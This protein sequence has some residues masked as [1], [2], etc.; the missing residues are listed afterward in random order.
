MRPIRVTAVRYFN[1]L[2]L[3]EGLDRLEDLELSTAAPSHIAGMLASGDAD[4]G[5]VSLVD[6]VRSATPFTVLPVGMIG[7]EGPTLTVRIYSAVEPERI[8][9][10]HA[11]T[12]SHTSVL[13]ARLLL[14]HRYGVRPRIVDFDARE[15]V[16]RTHGETDQSEWPE[17]LLMIGNKVVTDSPPAVRYPHQLDLG[18]QWHTWTSRPF[19][20]AAWMCRSEDL[21]DESADRSAAIRMAA[22][23]LDR[24]R[25]HNETRLDWIVTERAAEHRWP[26]DLARTYLGDLL[27]FDMGE[28]ERE[29][30]AHFLSLCAQSGYLP[31]ATLRFGS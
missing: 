12:D 23:L 19:V 1:T 11:D 28:R 24:Q 4:I 14:E 27:R 10:L 3:I 7:C 20:Y 26:A 18:E 5:L 30:S 8:T 2:P 29:A 25:R 21:E 13:L 16:T 6:A 31:E 22:T 15:R 17:S 9:T